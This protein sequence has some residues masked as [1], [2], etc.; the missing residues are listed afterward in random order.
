MNTCRKLSQET[1][2]GDAKLTYLSVAEGT[3]VKL[4]KSSVLNTSGNQG[5]WVI[6]T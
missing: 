3:T 2:K 1:Q 6:Y 4:D 5:D